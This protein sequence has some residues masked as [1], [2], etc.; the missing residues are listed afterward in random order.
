MRISDWSSDVCSSDLFGYGELSLPF[1]SPSNSLPLVNKCQLVGAFRFEDH[2]G[3]DQVTTPKVGVVYS[4]SNGVDFKA[5]WGKSFKVPTL[6]QT[7]Q[8]SNAQL[9]P[10]FIFSPAPT[11]SNP[12]LY[13]FGGNPNLTPER[14]TTFTTSLTV[15][16]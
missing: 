1:V 3:I 14:A 10:G 2:R 16:I 5:S 15:E 13:L 4:P 12:V 7:G 11:S 6:Y 9:L 8:T